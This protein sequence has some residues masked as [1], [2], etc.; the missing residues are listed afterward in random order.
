MYFLVDH[1]KQRVKIP[2]LEKLHNAEKQCN[3]R[4]IE[5]I[6]RIDTYEHKKWT[7]SL[8]QLPQLTLG[9]VFSYLV[10]GVS[11]YMDEQFKHI[12]L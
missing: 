11:A 6:N 8:H 2:Y 9:D 10:C 3:I 4:K 5:E 7:E 12:N 1:S